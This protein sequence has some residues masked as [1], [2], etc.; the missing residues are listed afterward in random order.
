MSYILLIA[1]KLE[2][3]VATLELARQM[4]EDAA[5]R[6]APCKIAEVVAECTP[7]PTPTWTEVRS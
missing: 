3:E 5:L 1:G 7:Y 2:S 4:A 6:G